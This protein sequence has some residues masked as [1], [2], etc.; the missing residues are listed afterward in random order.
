MGELKDERGKK[1]E[2]KWGWTKWPEYS[3]YFALPVLCL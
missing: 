3:G 2:M 1:K